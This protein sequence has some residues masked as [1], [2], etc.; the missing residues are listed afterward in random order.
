MEDNH[1]PRGR[2]RPI[3]TIR[4]TIKIVLEINKLDRNMGYMIEHYGVV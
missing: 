3:K 2:G 1:I 4:E